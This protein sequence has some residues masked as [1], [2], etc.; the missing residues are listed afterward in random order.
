MLMARE[1]CTS[2]RARYAISAYPNAFGE[3]ED[4]ESRLKNDYLSWK[5]AVRT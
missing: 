3:R 5:T 1:L 4:E 2:A